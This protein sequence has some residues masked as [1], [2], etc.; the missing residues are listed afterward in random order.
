MTDISDYRRRAAEL[1]WVKIEDVAIPEEWRDGREV[2]FANEDVAQVC[3]FAHRRLGS[4]VSMD[5]A[6]TGWGWPAKPTHYRA[7]P[8]LPDPATAL[9]S[10]LI[11]RV[12][13]LEGALQNPPK[14]DY[15][16]ALTS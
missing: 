14:H 16:R 7:M 2:M 15:W 1:G 6:W 13:A 5:G 10:D 3:F 12:E 9:I 8:S 4:P 11:A